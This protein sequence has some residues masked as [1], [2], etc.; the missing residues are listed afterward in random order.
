[1]AAKITQT[2]LIV[3][4]SALLAIGVA[5]EL[6][7]PLVETLDSISDTFAAINAR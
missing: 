1:M 2:A 5:T 7:G 6:G 3:A 4:V